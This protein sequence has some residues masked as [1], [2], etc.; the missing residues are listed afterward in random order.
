MARVNGAAIAE[1]LRRFVPPR[2]SELLDAIA[3]TTSDSEYA[4][5]VRA[6]NRERAT[7]SPGRDGS[8][9]PSEDPV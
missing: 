9:V 3:M 1:E 8:T 2:F 6:L 7:S 5:L 4:T